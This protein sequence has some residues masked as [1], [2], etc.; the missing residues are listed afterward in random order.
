[1]GLFSGSATTQSEI[2]APR[3]QF[4]P[5][6]G[7][8]NFAHHNAFHSSFYLTE[9]L[10]TPTID[11][12]RCVVLSESTGC[13]ISVSNV[14]L[15]LTVTMIQGIFFAR[16]LPEQGMFNL[17]LRALSSSWWCTTTSNMVYFAIWS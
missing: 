17:C 2:A 4:R 16:F 11:G 13:F 12:C 15:S 7:I 10:R 9:I 14:R 6:S 3:L 5:I 1:L 8:I